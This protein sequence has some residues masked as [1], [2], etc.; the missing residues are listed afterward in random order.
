M[1]VPTFA[2]AR[3]AC[4][5]VEQGVDVL[6]EKPMA[7]SL[8]EADLLGPR[9]AT[10]GMLQVGHLERFNPAIVAVMPV[11]NRPL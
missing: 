8:A 7:A 5:L 2:H 4:Q 10:D 1:A 6:V 3:T 11:V 9:H